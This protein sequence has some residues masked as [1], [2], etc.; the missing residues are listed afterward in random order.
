MKTFNSSSVKSA[1]K[2]AFTLGL[3]AMML[4]SCGKSK[5]KADENTAVT[6]PF[7][8]NNPNNPNEGAFLNNLMS[9]YNCNRVNR[10][11]MY[12]NGQLQATGGQGGASV[13]SY[14]GVDP[15]SGDIIKIDDFGNGTFQYALSICSTGDGYYDNIIINQ[16]PQIAAEFTGDQNTKT[17]QCPVGRV[18]S[19][20]LYFGNSPSGYPIDMIFQPAQQCL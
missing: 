9:Q 2:T 8:F 12:S 11:L 3:A 18:N 10:Y 14:V 7:G 19:G 1:A 16:L 13:A 20:V 17:A 15:R 4:V 5:K 6:N